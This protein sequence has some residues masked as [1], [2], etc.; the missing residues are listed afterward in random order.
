[1]KKENLEDMILEIDI[2]DE[3]ERFRFSYPVTLEYEGKQLS[4]KLS[5]PPA[6]LRGDGGIFVVRYEQITHQEAAVIKEGYRDLR[7]LRKESSVN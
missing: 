3:T 1:M 7:L 5:D 2:H 6:Y 4:F